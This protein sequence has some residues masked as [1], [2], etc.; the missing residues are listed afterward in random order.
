M[1]LREKLEELRQQGLNEIANSDDLKN[2]NDI[3]VKLLGK[4]GPITNVLRGM[5]V[6]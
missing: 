4:K 2:V 6:I 1:G 5:R 3:R